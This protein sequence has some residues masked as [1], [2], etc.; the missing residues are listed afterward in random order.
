MNGQNSLREEGVCE[1]KG[2][3]SALVFFLVAVAIVIVVLARWL[4]N[5]L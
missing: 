3:P 4:L 2:F 5:T 1:S